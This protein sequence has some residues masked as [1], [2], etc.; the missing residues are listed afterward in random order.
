V[1]ILSEEDKAKGEGKVKLWFEPPSM[2][3]N[4]LSSFVL[5]SEAVGTYSVTRSFERCTPATNRSQSLSSK[6]AKW[7][8]TKAGLV[9]TCLLFF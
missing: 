7:E 8:A 1:V 4:K 3:Y 2:R 6:E 9:C 5:W